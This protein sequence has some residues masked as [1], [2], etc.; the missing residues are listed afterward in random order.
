MHPAMVSLGGLF[1]SGRTFSIWAG[2][3]LLAGCGLMTSYQ[4]QRC[5]A[6]LP[7]NLPCE[8]TWKFDRKGYPESPGSVEALQERYLEALKLLED[9]DSTLKMCWARDRV[10][11]SAWKSCGE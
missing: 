10:V 4:V 11:V 2:V 7:E 5:P 8:R 3:L 1:R 9:A 6:Q